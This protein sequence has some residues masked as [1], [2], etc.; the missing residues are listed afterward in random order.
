MSLISDIAEYMETNS[1]G[2]L[3]TDLFYS[4]LPDTD[5]GTVIAVL[6]TGGVK[7]DIDIKDLKNPTFQVMVRTND[8]STGKTKVDAIR[9]LL[10]N[11]YETAIGSYH[12]LSINLISEGGHLGRN[13]RGQDEFSLNFICKVR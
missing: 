1:I 9:A 10:H 4:Y 6:D 7:P 11:V 8:Y 2:T 13:E 12:F 3:G 5:N